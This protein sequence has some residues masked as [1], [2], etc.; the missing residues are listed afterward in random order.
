MLAEAEINGK[1][2]GAIDL[3]SKDVSRLRG[4]DKL[5]LAAEL[6]DASGA[7]VDSAEITYDCSKFSEPICLKSE[8]NWYLLGAGLIFVIAALYFLTKHFSNKGQQPAV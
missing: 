1:M 8:I 3:L 2:T 6:K 4:Y 5:V 7:V